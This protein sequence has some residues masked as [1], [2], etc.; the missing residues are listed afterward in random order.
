MTLDE[1]IKAAESVVAQSQTN[2]DVLRRRA[3]T[4][5]ITANEA[6][7][8]RP[9]PKPLPSKPY[10]FGRVGYQPATRLSTAPPGDE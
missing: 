2:L 10:R 8:D 1:Q 9:V 7:E 6:A 3:A 4:V 5:A